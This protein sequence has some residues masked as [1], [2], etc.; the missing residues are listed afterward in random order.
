MGKS[1]PSSSALFPS[2]SVA[3]LVIVTVAPVT[4]APLASVTVPVKGSGR[5]CLGPQASVK[6]CHNYDN[7]QSSEQ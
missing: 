5:L 1:R 3:L 6:A 2:G 4:T 7:R